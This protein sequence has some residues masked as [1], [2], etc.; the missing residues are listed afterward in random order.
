MKKLILKNDVFN[1]KNSNSKAIYEF[2]EKNELPNLA[3]K[4]KEDIQDIDKTICFK[5]KKP[6]FEQDLEKY[7]FKIIYNDWTNQEESYEIED[8]GFKLVIPIKLNDEGYSYIKSNMTNEK[9]SNKLF[10]T[11]R[12]MVNSKIIIT[13]EIQKKN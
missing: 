7:G 6:R 9:Y 2:L 8:N 10:D 3:E 5:I 11:L 13:E 4:F 1:Y 12:R